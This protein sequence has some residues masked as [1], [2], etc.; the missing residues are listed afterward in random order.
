MGAIAQRLGISH[1]LVTNPRFDMRSES[2]HF[3]ASLLEE[4]RPVPW[5]TEFRIALDPVYPSRVDE[6]GSESAARIARDRRATM[7]PT[8]ESA[9]EPAVSEETE[10]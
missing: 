9:P 6:R 8:A 1:A 3:L 7:E 5:L 4:A 2:R 10:H